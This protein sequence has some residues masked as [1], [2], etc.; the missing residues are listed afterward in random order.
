MTDST[1]ECQNIFPL[2]WFDHFTRKLCLYLLGKWAACPFYSVSS[3]LLPN[4]RHPPR[5]SVGHGRPPTI[6]PC[7][8]G[9]NPTGEEHPMADTQKTWYKEGSFVP[10]TPL[11]M[12]NIPFEAQIICGLIIVALKPSVS[13][14]Q[15]SWRAD[16][17]HTAFR[18]I[19]QLFV[20]MHALQGSSFLCISNYVPIKSLA[21]W[22][23]KLTFN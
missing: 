5:S 15:N 14:S 23:D 2:L 16:S 4:S 1:G 21:V 20:W 13:F 22:Y 18:S 12:I 10:S 19:K 9:A 11:P 17:S 6:L 3:N 8:Y 7:G